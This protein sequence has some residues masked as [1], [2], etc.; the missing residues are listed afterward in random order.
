MIAVMNGKRRYVVAFVKIAQIYAQNA[1]W[2][3]VQ[4]NINILIIKIRLNVYIRKL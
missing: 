2:K 3:I 4:R 1:V